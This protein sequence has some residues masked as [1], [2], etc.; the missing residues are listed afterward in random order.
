MRKVFV[1]FIMCVML[2]S[3]TNGELNNNITNSTSNIAK[4]T[5]KYYLT[6]NEILNG[7]L[8]SKKLYLQTA[9]DHSKYKTDTITLI[10]ESKFNGNITDTQSNSFLCFENDMGEQLYLDISEKNDIFAGKYTMYNDMYDFMGY[11]EGDQFIIYY[12]KEMETDGNIAESGLVTI[13]PEYQLVGSKATG[14]LMGISAI[15][16]MTKELNNYLYDYDD[17]EY[18][19][20]SIE[21]AILRSIEHNSLDEKDFYKEEFDDGSFYYTDGEIDIIG[22]ACY[23]AYNLNSG[24]TDKPEIF[25]KYE[26]KG[27]NKTVS[28]SDE[29]IF[30]DVFY[31]NSK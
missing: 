9:F 15:D 29:Y 23:C 10:D 2:I 6:D 12:S 19:C 13:I 30:Y 11:D 24:I 4:E 21:E 18:S 17:I 5:E 20:M 25:I 3:C 16:E 27:Y 26:V 31:N 28:D 22:T 1:V 8:E 7:N 14:A